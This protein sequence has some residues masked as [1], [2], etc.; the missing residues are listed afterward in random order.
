MKI[1]GS[2]LCAAAVMTSGLAVAEDI[3]LDKPELWSNPS[4]MTIKGEDAL[5]ISNR[6]LLTS[7]QTF[8]IDAAKT[9]KL[10]FKIRAV[11]EEA[12][13]TSYV[14][15]SLKD[16]RNQPFSPWYVNPLKGT[17][18]ELAADVK[19]GD[20]I[21]K[22]KATK[23]WNNPQPHWVVAFDAVEDFSDLPNRNISP[24]I[25]P[26]NCKIVDGFYEVALL[27]PMNRE[28]SA[29]TKIRAHASGGY[30][31]TWYGK[32]GAD[33]KEVST[34]IQGHSTHGITGNK[35]WKGAE[36]FNVLLLANWT[37]NPKAAI[38]IKDFELDIE[39]GQ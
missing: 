16:A 32:P 15:F 7:K 37:G 12:P 21:L 6:H 18:S 30:M 39:D 22:L 24:V 33:W 38:E 36:M 17:E 13:A 8:Q 4:A 14:G 11:G 2:F 1:F 26:K 28:I 27:Q 35:W 5:S 19:K 29:G 20:K 3:D 25:V 9:Y 10:S 34:Q 31:Y 23:P